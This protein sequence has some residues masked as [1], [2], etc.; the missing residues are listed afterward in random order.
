MQKNLKYDCVFLVTN[1]SQINYKLIKKNSNFIIDTRNIF[2][3]NDSK[4]LKL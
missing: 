3:D 1:H 2:K 4:I